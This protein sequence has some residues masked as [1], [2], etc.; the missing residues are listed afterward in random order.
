[1]KMWKN[2]YP[3]KYKKTWDLLNKIKNERDTIHQGIE[4]SNPFRERNVFSKEVFLYE[5]KRFQDSV[6]E[7]KGFIDNLPVN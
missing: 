2:K 3:I 6:E 5:R 1:M 7:L 4:S